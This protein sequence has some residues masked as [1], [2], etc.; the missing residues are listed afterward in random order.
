[1]LCM[2]SPVKSL[3]KFHANLPL[4]KLGVFMATFLTSGG[5]SL[6]SISSH[7]FPIANGLSF[8]PLPSSTF[9]SWC[10]LGQEPGRKRNRR[11]GQQRQ[12]FPLFCRHFVSFLCHHDS[13]GQGI[14]PLTT[15]ALSFCPFKR[16]LGMIY[17]AGNVHFFIPGDFK[18]HGQMPTWQGI[19]S[20][21]TFC[22]TV[23]HPCAP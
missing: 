16:C 14:F 2:L 12:H 7:L 13:S 9:P 23:C 4:G 1:M 6:S 15:T 17:D 21:A 20:N 22:K 10:H 19:Q 18:W 5:F 11:G 3:L 8:Q